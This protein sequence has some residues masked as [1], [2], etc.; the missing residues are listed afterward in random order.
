MKSSLCRPAVRCFLLFAIA[1]CGFVN[2]ADA[3]EKRVLRAG[4]AMADI[5][6]PLGEMVVGGF[7]PFPATSIHDKLYAKC[8]V[9]DDGET[10]IA[11]V[12]CDN[13]GIVREV[14][15]QAR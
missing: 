3:M 1:A 7:A 14:Y 13:L 11:L 12:I 10:Q 2:L 8:L 5:T 15:D 9:L 6:P 4:A